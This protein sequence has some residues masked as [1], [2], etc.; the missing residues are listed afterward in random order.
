MRELVLV[1]LGVLSPGSA[2]WTR[3]RLTSFVFPGV[4]LSQR[5]TVAELQARKILR[6]NEYVEVTDAQDY[7][8]RADKPWT[9]LTP[10]DKVTESLLSPHGKRS[11]PGWPT[12]TGVSQGDLLCS[13]GFTS[14][15][16]PLPP[17]LCAFT[18]MCCLMARWSPGRQ[19]LKALHG[20]CLS[21]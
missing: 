20:F 14:S 21:F 11:Q 9:K 19:S 2:L 17:H 1:L 15:P 10:A 4:Q 6:F 8:R 13:S 3:L 7:D 16:F 5:P 18:C 12:Q